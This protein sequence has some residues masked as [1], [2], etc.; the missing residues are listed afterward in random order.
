MLNRI[1]F[2]IA[3]LSSLTLNAQT[4]KLRKADNLMSQLSYAYALTIYQ[5]LHQDDASSAAI[6]RNMGLCYAYLGDYENAEIAFRSVT[7]SSDA[8]ANDF[9]MLAEI[10]KI[11]S[12][13]S[14]SKKYMIV[15]SDLMPNDSRSKRFKNNPDYVE[16]I[17]KQNPY[18]EIFQLAGNSNSSD[19]GAYPNGN[20]LYVISSRHKNA[21]VVHEWS[22][23]KGRFLD[24]YKGQ[25]T[26]ANGISKLSRLNKKT[27]TKF[28]E[29]P[30]CFAADG[31]TVY[32][33]RNNISKGESRRDL[34]G[35]QNLKLYKAE[36]GVNG[37]WGKPTELPFNSENY[38]IGHP[39]LSPDGN[40][41]YFVSDMPG[42]FGGT[43]IYSVVINAD[44]SYGVPV[45]LGEN[46]NTEGKEMFPWVDSENNMY[47]S[48]NGHQGLGGLD[49]FAALPNANGQYSEV[50][51]L[52]RPIN[53]EA[54]DFAFILLPG[55]QSGF[56]S[57][58]RKGGQG[59]D[60]IYG[61]KQI[62][63]FKKV[64]NLQ[65]FVK[66]FDNGAAIENASVRILDKSSGQLLFNLST[67]KSG[68]MELELEPNSSF[69]IEISGQ[70]YY[71][72]NFELS[73]SDGKDDQTLIQRQVE[74][75][76]DPGLGIYAQIS[77]VKSK[78][79]IKEV[80]VVITDQL[81]GERFGDLITNDAGEIQRGIQ[82]KVVN[83]DLS[84]KIELIKEGYFPKTVYYSS[85]ITK[86][87]LID[88]SSAL[89]NQ[90]N[91]DPIVTDLAE[92]V[93]INPINFDLNKFNIRPDAAAELDKIVA[94]MNAYPDMVVELGS[95][96]DCRGSEQYN[97]NLSD[98][99]AKASAAYIKAR[100]TN[101]ERIYGKGY[102]ESKL[103]NDCGCEGA[104]KSDCSEEEHAK[105]R[106]T[107][108]RVI[109]FGSK[110]N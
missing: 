76:K 34:S 67:N 37:Q 20:E 108:F 77:D 73:T 13:A 88:L 57:S 10:L 81:T 22:W 52:G 25:I 4:G 32:F 75:K 23:N 109:S 53:S 62:R 94:I 41:L 1:V 95:H 31:K 86:P 64:L 3:F 105:N 47:F 82:G 50:M 28:H 84:L 2:L 56:V 83:D 87:G 6:S 107:E 33:T 102:G 43:D 85:K 42:G 7:K 72:N 36:I 97:L 12:K 9:L 16:N 61:F 48:S 69:L 101:P 90:L 21:S 98:K 14:E 44:G 60:D 17:N 74:L 30:L 65:L 93:Q 100:I 40:T 99:R 58:N 70:N 96:T 55:K 91:L 51:N 92:M 80:K 63:A 39:T 54:D 49:V 106:R 29:G 46:I 8:T 104:V 24:V 26:A 27:N 18:F 5:K 66:D 59:D 89:K 68:M 35:V 45:N 78:A 15:Y 19:F 110:T 79:P 38:S 103:M 71:S 11:N